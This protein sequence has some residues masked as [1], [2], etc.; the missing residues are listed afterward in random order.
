MKK[1]LLII[2]APL[3]F[4]SAL[5]A[6]ITRKEA[7]RIVIERMSR[8]K[9]PYVVYETG[10]DLYDYWPG[11]RLREPPLPKT[12]TIICVR[13]T[14]KLDYPCWV[15]FVRYSNR[16]GDQSAPGRYLIVNGN[17][18][19]LLEINVKGD[20]RAIST[21]ILYWVNVATG[22]DCEDELYYYTGYWWSSSEK[23]KVFLGRHF[24]NDYLLVAFMPEVQNSEIKNFLDNTGFFNP[25]DTT[26][27][28]SLRSLYFG[29]P[30]AAVNTKE[31]KSCSQLKEII[32]TLEQS[33]LVAYASLA[34]EQRWGN[35]QFNLENMPLQ[36][37][38]AWACTNFF[39]VILKPDY[40]LA[41]LEALL[42][43]T[44]TRIYNYDSR[45]DIYA[46]I[47]DKESKGNA[48]QMSQYFYETGKFF[49]AE[50][51]FKMLWV[52]RF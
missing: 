36:R 16:V 12:N 45:T 47:V 41:D 34:F 38:D 9:P 19:S 17:N 30:A 37:Y 1:I 49:Y 18:G 11:C 27:I 22:C 40:N 10:S 42:V 15:Y 51:L 43:E 5:S 20:S 4:L 39:H 46:I 48:L 26:K 14:L 50:P 7:D 35:C 28:E 25:V 23:T 52:D 32:S 44:N 2:I 6:Q 31:Q 3:I 21:N 24:V 29:F 13:D 8:E 33:H